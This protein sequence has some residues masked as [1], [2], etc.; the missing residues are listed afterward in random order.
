MRL[1]QIARDERRQELA[2]LQQLEQSIND[3][4]T[5]LDSQMAELRRRSAAMNQAGSID[6]DR[7]RETVRY[8]SLLAARRQAALVELEN[9]STQVHRLRQSL[10][11]A[12]RELKSLE[13]LQS[14][15]QDRYLKT[16]RKRELRQLDEAGLR[17]VATR[18]SGI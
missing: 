12:D 3:Q 7:L 6:V 10:V 18:D 5:S 4:I 13:K 15:Q 14:R 1:R 8:Q 17:I 16:E 11:K 2:A 9:C